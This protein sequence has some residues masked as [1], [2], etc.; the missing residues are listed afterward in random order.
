MTRSTADLSDEHG[1]HLQ[2]CS[3]QW[4]SLGSTSAFAGPASTVRCRDDNAIVRA[5]VIE[6]GNGRVLVV[7]GAGSLDFALVGDVLAGLAVAN[8]WVGI[9]VD[10][11][12]RDVVALGGLDIGVL[13]P[14]TNPRR[15]RR[16]GTGERDVVVGFGGVTVRPGRPGPGRRGR[17][18]RR[19][20]RQRPSGLI[21][22]AHINCRSRMPRCRP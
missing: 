7:D 11:A 5:A 3:L 9:V 10:G 16:Q 6:P 20:G 1:P 21:C 8:G 14:S 18:A 13:A 12:A 2:A 17:I 22:L 15:A 19:G 4:R